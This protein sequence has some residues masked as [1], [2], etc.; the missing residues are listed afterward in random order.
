MSLRVA[1]I[2]SSLLSNNASGASSA[3]SGSG[4]SNSGVGISAS[5]H[6]KL[7]GSCFR[8]RPN[9]DGSRDLPCRGLV[10]LRLRPEYLPKFLREVAGVRWCYASPSVRRLIRPYTGAC[11][12]RRLTVRQ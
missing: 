3:I 4:N 12:G 5:S 11:C 1:A 8:V 6:A 10:P 9:T 7:E 2:H